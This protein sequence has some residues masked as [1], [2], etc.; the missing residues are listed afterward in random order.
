MVTE[1]IIE[2]IEIDKS[3]FN[4]MKSILTTKERQ[5][6]LE[7]WNSKMF[8]EREVNT[9]HFCI[10]QKHG[11]RTNNSN[12]VGNLNRCSRFVSWLFFW[13]KMC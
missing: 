13:K 1:A 7:N 11:Q 10:V 8:D 4:N 2:R 6:K 9:Q 12:S 3:T 5:G